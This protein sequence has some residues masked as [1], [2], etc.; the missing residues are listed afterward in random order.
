MMI[1]VFGWI[2]MTSSGNTIPLLLC[3]STEISVSLCYQV[4]DDVHIVSVFFYK[5]C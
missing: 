5:D 1:G 3:G 2:V 4:T